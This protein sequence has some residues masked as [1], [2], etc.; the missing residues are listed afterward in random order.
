MELHFSIDQHITDA[1]NAGDN[2][3]ASRELRFFGEPSSPQRAQMR[4]C[5]LTL[6]REQTLIRNLRAAAHEYKAEGQGAF[7]YRL[8]AAA[9]CPGERARCA[10]LALAYL[11]GRKLFDIEPTSKTSMDRYSQLAREIAT[12]AGASREEI[13]SWILASRPAQ[14]LAA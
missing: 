2:T 6:V 4:Q 3:A 9:R 5:R 10:N 13:L 7:A 11:N 8:Q 12:K 14:R 1:R